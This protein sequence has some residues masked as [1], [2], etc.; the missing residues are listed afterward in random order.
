MPVSSA[1][2]LKLFQGRYFIKMSDRC[3]AHTQQTEAKESKQ[4]TSCLKTKKLHIVSL[5]SWGK[6]LFHSVCCCSD[7]RIKNRKKKV[8]V[9]AENEDSLQTV[10]TVYRYM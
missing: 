8:Q 5:L 2:G 1:S 9:V 10:K 7:E 3:W 6:G 4:F